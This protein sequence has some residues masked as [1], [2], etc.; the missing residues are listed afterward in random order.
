MSFKQDLQKL[1]ESRPKAVV[2]LFHKYGYGKVKKPT[3]QMVIDACIIHK[4]KF[5]AD[6]ADALTNTNSYSGSKLQEWIKKGIG[7]LVGVD[8]IGNAIDNNQDEAAQ[9]KAQQEKEDSN[10]IFGF[11]ATLVYALIAVIV[12]S[13]LIA[14]FRRA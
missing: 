3:A 13:L 7:A 10:T 12:I 5:Q 6:L 2:Q 4:D 1:I 14:V 8:A 9:Q 11:N